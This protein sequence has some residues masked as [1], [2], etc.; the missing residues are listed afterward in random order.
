MIYTLAFM[1]ELNITAKTSQLINGKRNAV[2]WDGASVEG[3]VEKISETLS[4]LNGENRRLYFVGGTAGGEIKRVLSGKDCEFFDSGTE[5]P[6]NVT[7]N[8]TKT[9]VL[10]SAGQPLDDACL[11]PLFSYLSK[12]KEGDVLIMPETISRYVTDDA[13][14]HVFSAVA[15]RSVKTVVRVCAANAK[16]IL[17]Y[18]PYCLITDIGELK[19][20]FGKKP[21]NESE[22]LSNMLLLQKKG[23]QS[24]IVVDGNSLFAAGPMGGIYKA[25]TYVLSPDAD[26]RFTAS[27]AY[28]IASGKSFESSLRAA[29]TPEI[30]EGI[31]ILSGQ[32]EKNGFTVLR[33]KAKTQ[34]IRN[35]AHYVKENS[36]VTFEKKPLNV[37]DLAVL[38]QL[39]MLDISK[40]P[41][42]SMSL[43]A[44]KKK[45]IEKNPDGYVDL[46]VIVPQTYPLLA[47]CAD[48][49]RF[50][51][52]EIDDRRS[53]ID[54]EKVTQFTA[55]TFRLPT[56]EYCVAF[57]GTD[58][59]IV[60]WKEDFC[61]LY[62]K[63]TVSQEM[64]AEY[65][66]E[67]AENTPD[68]A[69]IYVVGHSK[70]GNLAMYGAVKA[71]KKLHSKLI[72]VY[73]FDGP[74]FTEAFYESDDF[75]SV[76]DKITSVIP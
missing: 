53:V 38:S 47:L 36:S 13:I 7:V 11:K 45:Y 64:A 28:N 56:G 31:E 62:D 49:E 26:S 40:L 32:K 71:E 15:D 48:S 37:L 55:L 69:R 9:T 68:K 20:F 3:I 14:G 73:N 35:V 75:G 63:P 25:E 58:D 34:V 61:L 41:G 67:L 8:S 70:G 66:S 59:T 17:N 29:V 52:V 1:P 50:G 43:R 18:A 24:V 74:G 16:K 27:F 33:R 60:G 2:E 44:A 54:E 30:N 76:R 57:N 51:A 65:L 46:G 72:K 19:E 21:V 5:N 39:T 42:D 4:R 12:L 10:A 22:I 6:L 23:A